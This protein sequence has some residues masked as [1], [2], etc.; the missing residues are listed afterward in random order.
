[1]ATTPEFMCLIA[2]IY[3]PPMQEATPTALR[4]PALLPPAVNE[5]G[6]AADA[7][8]IENFNLEFN[9][10]SSEYEDDA[11]IDNRYISLVPY[12]VRY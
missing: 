1:M 6:A 2:T 3:H 11:R 10:S 4:Y 12:Q 7:L 9:L 8:D 5:R